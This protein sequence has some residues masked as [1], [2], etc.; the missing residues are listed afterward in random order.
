V[1]TVF[2]AIPA[3]G[4]AAVVGLTVAGQQIASVFFDRWGL[5]RMPKKPVSAQR[6]LGVALLLLGVVLIQ[7]L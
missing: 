4:A 6:L 7:A 5:M 2:M 1:T 3:S